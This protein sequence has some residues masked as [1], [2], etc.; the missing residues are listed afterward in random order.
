MRNGVIEDVGANV[1]APADAIVIDGAGMNVYPGLIDMDNDAPIDTGED[2]TAAAGGGRGAPGGGGRG[3]A[4]TFATLEEAERA[5]RAQILRPDFIAAD[6]LRATSAELSGTRERRRHDGARD[7]V[8]GHLQGPERARE[9]RGSGRRP[10]DQHDRRLPQGPRRRE[11][12]GRDRTSTWRAAAAVR[13]I[14]V[15]CS[16]RS[17]SPGRACSTRSG[18]ATR[19]RTTRSTGGRGPRPLIEPALDALKPALARQIPVV[20]DANLSPRD[21]SR[22]RDGG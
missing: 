16:A 5:K 8:D 20:L 17:R 9:R 15:R 13:A 6:N 18:S 3:A 1:T 12:A 2:T 11:V 21:R 10:A 14:P 7:S 4:Q 22:A 19:R